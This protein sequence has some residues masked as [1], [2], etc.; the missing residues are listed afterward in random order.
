MRRLTRPFYERDALTV[1][2]DL[3][4]CVVVSTAGYGRTAVRLVEVEAYRGVLDPGSHGHRGPTPRTRTMYGPPGHLYVYRS[5]GLHWC[6]NVVCAPDG[7]CEAVLLRAGQ[8]VAGLDFMFER[9]RGI[10]SE[11]LLA[12]GPGRLAQAVG[13]EGSLDGA[14]LLRGGALWIAEDAGTEAMRRGPVAQTPRIG[15]AAGKGDALHW[16]FVVAKSPYA[17]RPSQVRSG[18]P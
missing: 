4:G 12:A 1:A 8:P 2:R 18:G 15:L 5:Y 3:I 17:S 16:R 10:T 6:A 7:V 14:T 9:R 13:L 11:R